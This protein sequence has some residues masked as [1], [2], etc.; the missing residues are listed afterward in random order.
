[1]FRLPGTKIFIVDDDPEIGA[2]LVATLALK[3]YHVNC[4]KSPLEALQSRC[5]ET[6]GLLLSDVVMPNAP[7]VDL[8]IKITAQYPARKVLLLLAKAQYDPDLCSIHPSPIPWVENTTVR[9]TL[10]EPAPV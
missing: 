8:A 9:Q 6:P 5:S 1:M 7:I 4:F 2:T 10:E 3:G